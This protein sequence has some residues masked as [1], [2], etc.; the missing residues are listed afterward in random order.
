[1]IFGPDAELSAC[2][3]VHICRGSSPDRHCRRSGGRP[4]DNRKVECRRHDVQLSSAGVS[5]LA[6]AARLWFLASR[7]DGSRREC[8]SRRRGPHIRS[9]VCELR[10]GL[11]QRVLVI[12]EARI[13]AQAM[14]VGD[15][16][17]RSE[18]ILRPQVRAPLPTSRTVRAIPGPAHDLRIAKCAGSRRGGSLNV[19]TNT[20]LSMNWK[21]YWIATQLH[22][23]RAILLRTHVEF[24][25]RASEWSTA[26][27]CGRS[28]ASA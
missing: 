17:T 20:Y 7:I 18:C 23:R 19:T 25:R 4:V 22:A 28:L 16:T 9:R 21:V 6:L 2:P 11:G 24:F 8:E 3:V 14:A 5:A 26:D 10:L 13:R 27:A 1:V 15:R 12:H